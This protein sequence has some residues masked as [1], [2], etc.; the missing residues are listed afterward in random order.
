MHFW[1]FCFIQSVSFGVR[2]YIR[3]RKLLSDRFWGIFRAKPLSFF[4]FTLKNVNFGPFY[5]QKS[6]WG[7]RNLEI[8]FSKNFQIFFKTLPEHHKM[9]TNRFGADYGA[10]NAFLNSV[11]FFFNKYFAKPG[12]LVP[13]LVIFMNYFFAK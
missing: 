3:R 1:V 4:S 2:K 10:P 8:H 7:N 9:S 12:F 13:T 5:G 11:L 6:N